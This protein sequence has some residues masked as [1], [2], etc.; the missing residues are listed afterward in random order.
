MFCCWNKGFKC[1]EIPALCASVQTAQCGCPC[2]GP[3]GPCRDS[4][5]VKCEAC[6]HVDSLFTCCRDF[7]EG[8]C[9]RVCVHLC[10]CVPWKFTIPEFTNTLIEKMFLFLSEREFWS[11]DNVSRV[12]WAS[13]S[14]M[15]SATTR[16]KGGFASLDVRD[17]LP[18]NHPFG[19]GRVSLKKKKKIPR[20]DPSSLSVSVFYHLTA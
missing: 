15:A 10:V 2:F 17:R 13:F 11:R 9:V 5:E 16:T 14:T 3:E 4:F 19:K 6:S 12:E 18:L 8:V 1:A 20:T 7:R